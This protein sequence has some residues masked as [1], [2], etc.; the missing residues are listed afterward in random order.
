MSRVSH[1][2]RGGGEEGEWHSEHGKQ[3]RTS[4]NEE[5][6]TMRELS[7]GNATLLTAV[8]GGWEIWES[9]IRSGKRTGKKR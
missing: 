1:G 8:K 7:W 3:W 6:N 5:K 9:I 4:G 2:T